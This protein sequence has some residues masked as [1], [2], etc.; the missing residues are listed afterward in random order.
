MAAVLS[1]TEENS[2]DLDST[3]RFPYLRGNLVKKTHTSCQ[4]Y[5]SLLLRLPPLSGRHFMGFR[6]YNKA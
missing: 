4:K 5:K 6:I 1:S 2:S 3:G